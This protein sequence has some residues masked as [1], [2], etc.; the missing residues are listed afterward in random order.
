MNSKSD[1]GINNATA[2]TLQL[3]SKFFELVTK[4]EKDSDYLK[5]NL[6]YFLQTFHH[7]DKSFTQTNEYLSKLIYNPSSGKKNTCEK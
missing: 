4:D 2:N 5:N 7:H 3:F 1:S 6:Q